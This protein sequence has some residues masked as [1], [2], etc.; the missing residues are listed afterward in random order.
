[1]DMGIKVQDQIDKVH[2]NLKQYS[3]VLSKYEKKKPSVKHFLVFCSGYFKTKVQIM[4][5]KY[6]IS[7]EI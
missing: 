7:I 5:V 2:A 1:M 3:S 6:C 4:K